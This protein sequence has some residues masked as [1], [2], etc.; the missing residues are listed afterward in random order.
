MPPVP[1]SPR[2]LAG[3]GSRPRVA[4]CG[5]KRQTAS[6]SALGSPRQRCRTWCGSERTD[7]S[8]RIAVLSVP[9]RRQGTGHGY[10]VEGSSAPVARYVQHGATGARPTG[11]A[12]E[13]PPLLSA[14]FEFS[15]L[16]LGR[17]HPAGRQVGVAIL[18]RTT[19][20]GTLSH[21]GYV[22]YPRRLSPPRCSAPGTD[23]PKHELEL[24]LACPRPVNAKPSSDTTCIF[25]CPQCAERRVP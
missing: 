18:P 10:D 2:P 9:S 21:P 11:E 4:R 12:L 23:T 16:P 5:Q 6:N 17:G 1:R 13:M 3:P 20:A 7:L 22:R 19:G 24:G 14:P 8:V 15:G 25:C